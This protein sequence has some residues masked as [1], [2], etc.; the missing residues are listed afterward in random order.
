MQMVV[1]GITMKINTQHNISSKK[2]YWKSN[3][4]CY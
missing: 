4:I 2:H 1:D 3:E